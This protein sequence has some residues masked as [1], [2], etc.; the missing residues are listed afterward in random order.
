MSFPSAKPL[1]NPWL[2]MLIGCAVG[3]FLFLILVHNAKI[4]NNPLYVDLG[5]EFTLR[6]GG[7]A[8]VDSVLGVRV[9]KFIYAPCT[10][11]AQCVWSG[12]GVDF[13]YAF[14]GETTHGVNLS[15]AFGYQLRVV[16][17]NYQTY[18]KVSVS[19][20]DSVK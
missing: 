6:E 14:Q 16:D 3:L 20:M 12:L 13:E 10:D 17:T 11:G 4:S 8:T 9:L 2:V 15:Q 19:K 5:Q 7:T 18:A 1:K